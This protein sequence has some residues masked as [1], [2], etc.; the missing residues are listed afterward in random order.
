MNRSSSERRNFDTRLLLRS[1]AACFSL[2][3]EAEMFA[4]FAQI[5]V[6]SLAL[7]VGHQAQATPLAYGSY[8]DEFLAG[9]CSTGVCRINFSQVPTD[10]LV[11]ISKISCSAFTAFPV[12][13][14]AFQV[15]ATAGGAPLSRTLM[16]SPPP[17][18]LVNGNYYTSFREDTH[19]LIGQGRFPF[20]FLSAPGVISG[21][22]Q[23][24]L[25]GDLV[26]PV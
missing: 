21:V 22:I 7:V 9:N 20:V 4:R 25:I 8:Y 17:S 5:A 1:N 6:A 11:M 14:G 19:F 18:Q 15:S 10:K 26:S 2:R 13:Q 24:T 12:V 16:L 23:C 3:L